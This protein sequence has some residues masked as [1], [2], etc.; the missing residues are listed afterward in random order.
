MIT[1]PNRG[2]G[3]PSYSSLTVK[4]VPS[5][6]SSKVGFRSE[7]GVEITVPMKPD[8]VLDARQVKF[9]RDQLTKW[10]AKNAVAEPE[11]PWTGTL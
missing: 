8:V 2:C 10:L 1:F 6:V 9:L 7:P 4:A 5:G 3:G 11:V